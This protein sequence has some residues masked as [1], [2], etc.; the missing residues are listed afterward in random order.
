M[1]R[2][3]KITDVQWVLG[4][5][6]LSTSQLYLTPAPAEVIAEV[7]AHHQRRQAGAEAPGAVPATGA[8]TGSGYRAE[9]LATLFSKRSS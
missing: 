4:H 3:L 1:T 7:L 9:S 5:A 2:K 8:E 6:R